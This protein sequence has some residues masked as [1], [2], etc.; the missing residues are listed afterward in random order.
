MS[1]SIRVIITETV[2]EVSVEETQ[3][4]VDVREDTIVVNI[5]GAGGGGTGDVVD[6]GNDGLAP[7]MGDASW[8]FGL[9]NDSDTPAWRQIVDTGIGADI[10]VAVAESGG[11][12][13]ASVLR[14]AKL[15]PGDY[16]DVEYSTLAAAL[17][18]LPKT[19]SRAVVNIGEGEFDGAVVRGFDGGVLDLVGTWKTP[20]LASGVTS[21]LAGAGSGSTIVNKPAAA[22]NWTAGDLVGKI[23]RPTSGTAFL[24]NDAF[25]ENYLRIKSN[26]TTQLV[27]E[28]S[29]F[30]LAAGDGFEIVEEGSILTGAAPEEISDVTVILGI[31]NC[32]A[33]IRM[34][35]IRI[36]N[37][38]ADALYGLA[39]EQTQYVDI[40]G[41]GFTAAFAVPGYSS[42]IRMLSTHL[43]AGSYLYC[44][45]QNV[46][47]LNGIVGE[48]STIHFERFQSLTASNVW[49]DG[50]VGYWN[51]CYIA[52]GNVATLGGSIDNCLSATPLLLENIHEFSVA[53]SL[54]GTNAARA[55]AIDVS[56]GGQYNLAG[57]TI[58]GNSA[59]SVVLAEGDQSFSYAQL[60]GNGAF[61]HKGTFL[62][63]GTGSIVFPESVNVFSGQIQVYAF[64][65][66]L[67]DAYKEVTAHAGGGQG[68]A[69]AVGY[70]GTKI[71]VCATDHDSV[72]LLGSADISITGGIS[73]R[74]WNGT[75]NIADLYPPTGQKI[76]LDGVDQGV[77]AAVPLA[78]GASIEWTLDNAGNYLVKSGGGAS[79]QSPGCVFGDGSSSD[80]VVVGS[81]A[82]V[83]VPYEGTIE[84]WDIVADVACTCVID[85][86]KVAGAV[87]TIANTITASAKP[88]LVAATVGES[89]TLTGWTTSVAIGDVIAFKLSSLS[90]GSPTQI[91]IA[92]RVA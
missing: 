62:V 13:A 44:Y 65:R 22:A 55:N 1:E 7:E 39:T 26:T 24:G 50:D 17:A 73:G 46:M 72:R 31:V 78:G 75:A 92:L 81:V 67:G 47:L 18:A 21:G 71:T 86:W 29:M 57:S 66:P 6:T 9:V 76:Y 33:D 82:Y 5:G 89:S 43:E 52:H 68:S 84:Q 69:V 48:D 63:W 56:G 42:N 79:V 14:P 58:A 64:L 91:A 10:E 38:D 2:N 74:V 25:D 83:R 40:G 28:S 32:S 34:R 35:R 87:P 15:R 8:G 61:M 16:T 3:I 12:D 20:T 85:V 77:N 45:G 23:F 19:L 60:S 49:L 4:R 51:A 90:G 80:S 30:G 41:C 37:T 54:A 27:L 88:Q 36:D 11:S 70:I 53:S 59:A